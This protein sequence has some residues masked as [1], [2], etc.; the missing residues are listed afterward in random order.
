MT[1]LEM[2]ETMWA[3]MSPDVYDGPNCDQ[4]RPRWE[5]SAEGDKGGADF[6]D[7]LELDAKTF[8]PGTRVII[9]VP[10]CPECFESADFAFDSRTMT[11]GKCSCGFDWNEWARDEYS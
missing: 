1:K 3:E 10:D 2:H 7:I 9:S 6:I 11:M 4:I 8:P 5:A